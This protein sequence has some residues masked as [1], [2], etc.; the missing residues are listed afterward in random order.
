MISPS[1]D[2]TLRYYWTI[3]LVNGGVTPLTS[4]WAGVEHLPRSHKFVQRGRDRT[5]PPAEPLFIPGARPGRRSDVCAG[6]P[7]P[8]LGGR[9]GCH[10]RPEPRGDPRHEGDRT[11]LREPAARRPDSELSRGVLPDHPGL[12]AVAP[13]AARPLA[14]RSEEHTSELQSPVHLVC[15]LLLE[16]KNT[17]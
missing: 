15:R 14:R 8:K 9:P 17:A 12:P 3:Y 11:R 4:V 7:P 13:A 5:L 16:K 10:A 2:V 6:D 1:Y